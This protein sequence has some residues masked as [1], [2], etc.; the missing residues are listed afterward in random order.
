MV[1]RGEG[2][3]IINISSV[4]AVNAAR[5]HAHYTASKAGVLMF[6]KTAALELGEH[7]IRVNAVAPGLINAPG[8]AEAWPEGLAGW[9]ARAPLTR[10]GEPEDISDACL[11]LASDAARWVTGVHLEVDGGILTAPAF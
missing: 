8:L 10:V 6:T 2:G 11:Y 4:E 3:S 7:G 1:E 9:L 5:S